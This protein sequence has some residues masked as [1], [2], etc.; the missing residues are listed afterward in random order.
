VIVNAR[1]KL[2]AFDLEA[3]ELATRTALHRAGA[4]LLEALL[5]DTDEEG[6]TPLCSCGSRMRCEGP[7][8]KRLVSL[9]GAVSLRRPYYHCRHCGR[10]LAPLDRELDIAGTQ[11]SPSVRRLLAVV[12]GEAPFA[13]GRALLEELAG[14]AVSVKAVERQARATGADLAARA[15]SDRL[16]A[17]LRGFVQQPGEPLATLYIEMDGTGIPVTAVAAAGRQ[18]KQGAT[19][20]TREVKLGC[21]FTQTAVDAEGRPLRDANS[22]TYTGAIEDAEAF[23]RRIYHE[24][25]QRGLLRAQRQVVLGDGAAWVW[26]LSHVYFPNAIEIV[27][28]YHAREHLW[29]L[30]RQLFP[31]D[32]TQRRRWVRRR[33]KQL[34]EGRIEHLVRSL[35]GIRAETPELREALR[36]EAAYFEGHADRMRYAEFRRQD[37]FVGSG[38]IE[39]GCRTVVGRLKRSGMFWTVA[40]ANAII[41]LRCAQLSKRFDDYWE[42]RA[43]A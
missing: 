11:Y 23:G 28:I 14:I 6:Q 18:G 5:Q 19:A 41:A 38:V 20:R 21:V 1:R 15:E 34:D 40:G 33:K 35:R 7:R 8:P 22:T 24:A 2:G 39:A 25:W 37:L 13:S 32:R 10:G 3:L 43:A 27:D 12:G 30:G 26:N 29:A 9:L 36:V 16:Q 17:A 4:Q 42:D 31:L